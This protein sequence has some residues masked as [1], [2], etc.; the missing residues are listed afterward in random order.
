[1]VMTLSTLEPRILVVIPVFDHASTLR[2]VTAGALAA[3]PHV[4]VV[5]DGS[6]DL[7]PPADPDCTRDAAVR[8]FPP[9]HPLH[10]LAALHIRHARN[11]G[12]GKAILT[13]ARCARGLGMTHIVTLDADGQHDPADLP[14]FFAA[15]R[16]EPMTLFVG[17]R[18]FATPNV[19]RSSRFGRAFSNF[20]FR[21][22]TGSDIGDSQSGFRAYPL[23]VLDTLSLTES[24]YSFETEVLVRAAWSG[25]TVADIPI[26]V[27][28]PPPSERVSHFRPVLDNVRLS[29]LNTRLTMRA[30]MPVP[31]KKFVQDHEGRITPLRPLSSLRI[32]LLH[33]ETPRNL[34]LSG[35]LGVLLGTLPLIGLHSILIILAA[36]ALKLNK[37]SGLATSQLCMPPLAPALCIETGHYLKHGT[38]LTEISWRTLGYEAPARLGEWLLGSLVLAPVFGLACGLAVFVLAVLVQRGLRRLPEREDERRV[39]LS[40]VPSEGSGH[41]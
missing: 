41:E 23:A 6:R 9:D 1:M 30:I 22:Q 13:A 4:L 26:R 38:L 8:N 36:G 15:I 14:A 32:L 19:P 16:R 5:D 31:Q 2:D 27:H 3:H 21:V 35:G 34:A 11:Q 39:E 37:V 24:H 12:K 17:T 10:E 28:Y 40:H 33:N 25:F 7:A 18:N 20:W 29:L